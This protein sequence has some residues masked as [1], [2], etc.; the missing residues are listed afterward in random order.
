MKIV[1][2]IDWMIKRCEN[3][4]KN[5]DACHEK[6]QQTLINEEYERRT[7]PRKKYILFGK[8]TKPKYNHESLI[9]EIKSYL[10]NNINYTVKTGEFYREN[11]MEI[12]ETLLVLKQG[13]HKTSVELNQKW[14]IELML[15]ILLFLKQ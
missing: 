10:M 3:I 7:K 15:L 4:I 2:E 11:A 13:Q 9:N 8:K 14:E 1:V 12:M 5:I 6:I